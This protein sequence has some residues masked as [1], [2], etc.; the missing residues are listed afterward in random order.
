MSVPE[1]FRPMSLPPDACRG[2]KNRL[3]DICVEECSPQGRF[4]RFEA[5]GVSIYHLPDLPSFDELDGVSGK[6]KY[7]L[8]RLQLTVL[9]N[10]MYK[11]LEQTGVDPDERRI[12]PIIY[13]PRSGQVFEN[14][15]GEN[16]L[17]GPETENH[18]G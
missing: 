8:V 15:Q 7:E 18:S 4:E 5:K 2:C 11:I 12:A 13:R 16:V 10:A 1:K 9:K 17:P 14:Q 6:I 3:T